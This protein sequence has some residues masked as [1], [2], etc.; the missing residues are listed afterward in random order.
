MKLASILLICYRRLSLCLCVC[1]LPYSSKTNGRNYFI[2]APMIDCVS[3]GAQKN[4][5]DLTFKIKVTRGQ[6]V[7]NG[8][9][10]GFTYKRNVDCGLARLACY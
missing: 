8:K 7:N 1:V 6:E 4:F 2:F 9:K 3:G 5:G 10:R